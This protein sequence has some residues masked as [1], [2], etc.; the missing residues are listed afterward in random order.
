MK[1]STIIDDLDKAVDFAAKLGV[2]PAS[3]ATV[4][5]EA[6]AVADKVLG[7]VAA[8]G[9]ITTEQAADADIKARAVQL[10][11]AA[12]Q[13]QAAADDKDGAFGDQR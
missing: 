4:A 10:V 1:L 11:S 13:A 7:A 8:I 9:G 2:I 6:T 5:D 3:A 12:A